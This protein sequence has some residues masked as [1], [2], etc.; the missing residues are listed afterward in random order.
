MLNMILTIIIPLSPILLT[1]IGTAG[2]DAFSKHRMMTRPRSQQKNMEPPHRAKDVMMNMRSGLSDERLVSKKMESTD[3]WGIN[4]NPTGFHLT[5]RTLYLILLL[6][7]TIMSALGIMILKKSLPAII[8]SLI[9]SSIMFGIII[10]NG[11][12]KLQSESTMIDRIFAVLKAHIPFDQS[13]TDPRQV[14][15]VG[16]WTLPDE[17]QIIAD[18]K[19][20]ARQA[21]EY[22]ELEK[23]LPQPDKKGRV[24]QA[25]IAQFR[26][27]PISMTV[28]FP[29][30][31]RSAGTDDTISHLNEA[32]GGKTEW[33]AERDVQD[34]KTGKTKTVNGWV[35]DE[36]MAYLRTVP[37]L[38]TIA[39][40]PEDLDKG[41]W[42]ELK[43]GVTVSGEAVWNINKTPM[44]LIPLSVD[45]MIWRYD[46]NGGWDAV[47]L[48]EIHAGDKVMSSQGEPIPVIGTTPRH[49]PDDMYAMTLINYSSPGWQGRVFTIHAAG[50]HIWPVDS[51]LTNLHAAELIG[52]DRAYDEGITPITTRAIHSIMR[53]GNRV[54]LPPIKTDMGTVHWETMGVTEETPTESMCINVES[55][56]HIFMIARIHGDISR[57]GVYNKDEE[58]RDYQSFHAP[59]TTTAMYMSIPTHN[60]GSP[61]TLDTPIIRSDG[62]RTTMGNVQVG[63]EIM[64][65]HGAT[66]VISKSPVMTPDSLYELVLEPDEDTPESI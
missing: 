1:I 16:Q 6:S 34:P 43:L 48:S 58:R 22:K 9:I 60:C 25:K 29:V 12:K 38:P 66:T 35:F 45:T 37:P 46:G 32:F 2:L 65:S 56:D 28:K 53:T 18:A 33:V 57:T 59:D 51:G 39:S 27:V 20:Q 30:T 8:A 55:D 13:I 4:I 17:P 31:F 63:D 50:S 44:S 26:T 10:S 54:Y 52:M 3:K 62:T 61:L 11:R 49:I 15:T 7:S 42:N 47:P 21:G 64:G 14:I 23:D 41:A 40:L 36:G 5:W 24:R 19:V